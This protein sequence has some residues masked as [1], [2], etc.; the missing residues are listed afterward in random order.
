MIGREGMHREVLLELLATAGGKHGASHLATGNL[1]FTAT[2]KEID[3][4]VRRL[5]SGIE[6]VLGR[7]EPVITRRHDWLQDFVAQD[8]F[9]GYDANDWE[10]LVSFLP[11]RAE[12]LDRARVA[13]SGGTVI[14]AVTEHELIGARPRDGRHPHV[15]QIAQRAAGTKAT[16]RGWSTLQRLARV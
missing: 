1:T 5:E 12:P 15:N 13:T 7:P 8:P 11:L 10:L 2:K 16:S 4:V 6:N 9:A 3:G 14:L